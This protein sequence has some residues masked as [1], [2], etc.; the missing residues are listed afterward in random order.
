MDNTQRI[1]KREGEEKERGGKKTTGLRGM[2]REKAG[3][4][5]REE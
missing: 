2:R 4:W 5:N 3:G 1:G